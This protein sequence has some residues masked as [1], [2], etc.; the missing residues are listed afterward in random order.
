MFVRVLGME[1]HVVQK[2]PQPSKPL[3]QRPGRRP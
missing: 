1:K 3:G 2:V